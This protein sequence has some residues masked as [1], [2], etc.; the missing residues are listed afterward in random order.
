MTGLT[1]DRYHN[2]RWNDGEAMPGVTG[3]VGTLDKSGPLVGWAK[4]ETAACAVRNI[5]MLTE[6]VETGGPTAA[7][8][9]LKKIPDYQRDKSADLGTRIHAIADAM[10][11]GSDVQVAEDEAPFVTSYM[12]WLERTKPQFVNTEFMVYSATHRYGGTCDAVAW[13]DGELTLIDYK[14]GNS[15]P[16]SVALQ[17][18]GYAR[19]DWIGRA[20]DPKRYR[21]PPVTHYAA[22][23]I[24]PE[25]AELVP[26]DLVDADWAG[27]LAARAMWDWTKQR[28]G[29]VKKQEETQ[30]AA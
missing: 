4:R 30:W 19:A 14:T 21:V 16:E 11:R 8:E 23:H 27:F 5:K 7:I 25:G 6:L 18:I 26:F 29:V 20:G 1:R 3:V 13:I 2:Y 15:I 22:L 10:S 17:L 12:R 9:W 28:A 24:R